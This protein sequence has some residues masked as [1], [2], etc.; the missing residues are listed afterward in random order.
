MTL[1]EIIKRRM[2]EKNINVKNL[3]DMTGI[4]PTTLYSFFRRKSDTINISALIEIA[5]ALDTNVDDLIKE[6]SF[7]EDNNPTQSDFFLN[8]QERDFLNLYRNADDHTRK[9]ITRLLKYENEINKLY[10]DLKK[11]KDSD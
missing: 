6:R 7:E 1:G 3:S 2:K 11:K 10:N 8:D 9:T 4:A 5:N